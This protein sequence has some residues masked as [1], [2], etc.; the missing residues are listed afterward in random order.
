MMFS[1]FN[2]IIY[3]FLILPSVIVIISAFSSAS[4]V[5]FPPPGF[6]LKWFESIS[7]WMESTALSL[8]LVAA[9]L[10]I[11]I[12]IGILTAY[13]VVR[14]EFKGRELVM[15][16]MLSP[17][18]VPGLLLGF[19]LLYEFMYIGI[20]DSLP[21]LIIAHVLVTVPYAIRTVSINMYQ[22]DIDLER[23]A[24]SLGANEMQTFLKILLPLIR[25]GIFS[26][27]VFVFVESLGEVA[28]TQLVTGAAFVT[29]PVKMFA[30]VS[31]SFD[32]SLAAISTIFILLSL[33]CIVT[34]NK[35]M[36]VETGA[37]IF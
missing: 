21:A 31:Q 14:H 5:I 37:R 34:V 7:Y 19:A 17:I 29:L 30:Y 22:L 16:L 23:A 1:L 32:P 2:V 3:L 26:A 33:V 15:S 24:K 9:V 11:T 10:P 6:S 12:T 35:L 13:A 28:V 4:Y 18:M 20:Q 8:K 27:A 25:P 36:G